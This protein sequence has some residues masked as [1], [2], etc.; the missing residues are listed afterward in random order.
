MVIKTDP[1]ND[2]CLL[3]IIKG[4]KFADLNCVESSPVDTVIVMKSFCFV[5]QISYA[6]TTSNINK[7]K[8][9][10]EYISTS[11]KIYFVGYAYGLIPNIGFLLP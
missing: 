9:T 3:F 7:Y 10:N 4:N 2:G 6:S 1:E 11:L 5:K 8:H